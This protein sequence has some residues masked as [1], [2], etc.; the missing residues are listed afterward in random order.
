MRS[1]KKQLNG[2]REPKHD[3]LKCWGFVLLV[4][5]FLFT[6]QADA[7]HA[8]HPH[9]HSELL[10]YN[11][12]AEHRDPVSAQA[13]KIYFYNS[14]IKT[15]NN[16]VLK[17]SWDTYL[18]RYGTFSFQPVD[19][20][21]RFKDLLA[22]EHSAAFILSEWLYHS[23]SIAAHP[24]YE[25][26]L[27]GMKDQQT[28]YHRVL[29]SYSDALDIA[30]SRIA[31]SGNRLKTLQILADI[32]PHL[33]ESQLKQLKI[34]EVPKDFDALFALSYGLA[35]FALA[36]ELSLENLA[37]LNE[38]RYKQLVVL[39]R[40][41]PLG[42]SVVLVKNFDNKEKDALTQSFRKMPE[43]QDGRQAMG[44]IG[45]DAWQLQRSWH[46]SNSIQGASK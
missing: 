10:A 42:Q 15:S 9:T 28:T 43:S 22:S 44:M 25:L 33:S 6:R 18:S 7:D 11:T 20:V 5:L 46:E 38:H 36:T 23:L 19:Q 17:S 24:E 32:Y 26:L 45:L 1:Q 27:Q 31:S 8:L 29:V 4:M 37:S 12:L 14:E 13:T 40:S 35:E 41:K 34:L 16:V 39:K 3:Q 2:S 21:E 30:S